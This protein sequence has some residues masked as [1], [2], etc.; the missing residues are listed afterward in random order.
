MSKNKYNQIVRLLIQS[1]T[2]HH[3]YGVDI[4]QDRDDDWQSWYTNYL[5]E[6]GLNDLLD[7][8]VSVTGLFELLKGIDAGYNQALSN[9]P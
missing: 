7:Y 6:H 3:D 9:L 4:I 1:K 2:A 8:G 5:T